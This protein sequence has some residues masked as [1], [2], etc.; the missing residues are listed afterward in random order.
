[1]KRKREDYRIKLHPAKR[2]VNM[3]ISFARP[4]ADHVLLILME[5]CPIKSSK[6][7]IFLIYF[8]H[9]ES[10]YSSK[11]VVINNPLFLLLC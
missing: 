1:M 6:I 4:T 5:K 3:S 10:H 2:Q 7:M 9:N 8:H 11:I